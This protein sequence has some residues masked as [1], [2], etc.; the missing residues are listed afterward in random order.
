MQII[1]QH[2]P[3]EQYFSGRFPKRNIVLHHTVSSTARSA[4]A[5]WRQT[6]DRVGTAYVIDKAGTIFEVFP[7][8]CW[9]H[10]LGLVERRNTLLNQQSIG[11]ELVNEGQLRPREGGGMEWN[12][13]G[14][15]ARPARYTGEQAVQTAH[16]WRGYDL[17]APYSEAQ[18]LAVFELV[19]MLCS[20]FNIPR[21]VCPHIDYER[22][23][24]AKYG[25]Y[26]HC[27]IRRDKF[28]LSPAFDIQRLIRHLNPPVL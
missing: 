25:I 14:P 10:H 5:W 24:N 28:D 13:V 4:I 8:E 12:F 27:N 20:Q 7:P 19:D 9:A 23:V 3:P 6:H 2:L 26:A 17:W 18:H 16:P 21:S 15:G 1:K 11:I 22:M